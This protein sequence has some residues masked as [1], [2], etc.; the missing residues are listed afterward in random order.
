MAEGG[1]EVDPSTSVGPRTWLRS[2]RNFAKTRF[3]RSPSS[4][5]SAPPQKKSPRFFGLKNRFTPFW[6]NFGGSTEKRTSTATSSQFFAL[7][8][9][10]LRP[11][12]PKIVGNM[13]VGALGSEMY[14]LNPP[15]PQPPQC[16]QGKVKLTM[17]NNPPY[18]TLHRKIQKK[19]F[20]VY[21]LRPLG[22]I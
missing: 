14:R 19:L 15:C 20:N 21:S 10:I 9:P 1:V 2:P 12:R 3:R 17:D 8:P 5:F 4:Q 7:D 13:S 22:P 6:S 16:R 11:V 18:K